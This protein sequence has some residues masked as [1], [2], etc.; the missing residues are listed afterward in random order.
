MAY[1]VPIQRFGSA[2]DDD[3]LG[4]RASAGAGMNKSG[5][6]VHA[7]G[8]FGEHVER[9]PI[10][11][12]ALALAGRRPLARHLPQDPQ[13]PGI[14]RRAWT[15]GGRA[16]RGEGQS[17]REIS[18][19]VGVSLAAVHGEVSAARADTPIGGQQRSTGSTTRTTRGFRQCGAASPISP[20]REANW[21]L[22]LARLHILPQVEIWV[23]VAGLIGIVIGTAGTVF[24]QHRNTRASRDISQANN[25]LV[26]RADRRA[27]IFAFLEAAQAV[28]MIALR[29]HEN[30]VFDSDEAVRTAIH[31]LWYRQKCVEVICGAEVHERCVD[32]SFR[33]DKATYSLPDGS[34]VW[35]FVKE[36]RDAFLRAAKSELDAS[37]LDGRPRPVQSLP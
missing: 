11:D 6:V 24:S 1:S 15:Q 12:L 28:D 18:R 4:L 16:R 17:L 32:Y 37:D 36:P 14:R 9:S 20:P 34:N 13:R 33:L 7:P 21:V 8:H 23:I 5:S 3:P 27:A 26:L 22:P 10:P 31:Q 30:Q 29:R 19:G 2:P 35:D 25:Q